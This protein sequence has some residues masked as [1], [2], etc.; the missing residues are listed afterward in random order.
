MEKV[1]LTGA[2]GYIG[3]RLLPYVLSKGYQVICPVRDPTRFD[4]KN[5]NED[6]NI[7]NYYVS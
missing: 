2:T 4:F 5:F 1:L 6:E 3:R 7:K